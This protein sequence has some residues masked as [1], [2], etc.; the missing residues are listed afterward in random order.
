LDNWN[1]N[2]LAEGDW[3][4]PYGQPFTIYD[5]YYDD[6]LDALEQKYRAMGYIKN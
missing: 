3:A 2:D 6:E 1:L 4:S 5:R